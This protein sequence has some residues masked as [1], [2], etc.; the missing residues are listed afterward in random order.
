[1]NSLLK[2]ALQDL[3]FDKICYQISVR[4]NTDKGKEVA[5]EIEISND[6]NIVEESLNKTTEDNIK[7]HESVQTL[8]RAEVVREQSSGLADT[9]AEKLAS[10]VEDIEYDNKDN[11]EMKVKVV[12]ESY[13]TKE[14][15]ESA[16]EVSSVAGTDEAPVEISDV[17][18]RYSQAISKLNK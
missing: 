10:L 9:E 7:L 11:F 8:E 14:I 16:D 4:C 6:F 18:D 5:L 12:K 13:F 2:K 17:M 3:E 1:M 15:N